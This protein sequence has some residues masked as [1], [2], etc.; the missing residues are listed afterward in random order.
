M[1]AWN[2]HQAHPNLAWRTEGDKLFCKYVWGALE[3]TWGEMEK[4]A[5]L[6]YYPR[7]SAIKELFGTKRC[8][9]RDAVTL[10][11]RLL[12]EGKIKRPAPRIMECCV[13]NPTEAV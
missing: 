2:S 4:L 9:K 1:D 3:T 7:R 5:K 11:T 13:L 12:A 8:N 10:F 6:N